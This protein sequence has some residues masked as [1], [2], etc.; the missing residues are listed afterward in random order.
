MFPPSNKP[1]FNVGANPADLDPRSFPNNPTSSVSSPSWEGA[2]TPS[3]KKV[4]SLIAAGGAFG[5]HKYL[6]AKNPNYAEGL[7]R[8]LKIAEERSPSHIGRTFALSQWMSSYLSHG[9]LSGTNDL[10]LFLEPKHLFTG[11][12]LTNTGEQV[13]RLLGL[14]PRADEF[15]GGMKF[16]RTSWSDPYLSLEGREGY[17][18]RFAERGRL[19]GSSF[20][21]GAEITKPVGSRSFKEDWWGSIKE[22]FS[23]AERKQYLKSPSGGVDVYRGGEKISFQPLFGEKPGIVGSS[24]LGKAERILFEAA[25]R[26]NRLLGQIGL[27]IESGTYNKLFHIPGIGEGGLLNKLFNRRIIPV[28]AGVTALRYL[29]YKLDNKPAEAI[30]GIPLKANVIRAEITDRF[31]GLRKLT[32]KYEDIVPGPQYGPLAL[33][34]AGAVVGGLLHYANVLKG[35]EFAGETARKLA[36]RGLAKKGAIIGAIAALPFV[37]GMIGSRK[38]AGELRSI[39]SGETE[40][41]IRSGR[42]WSLGSTALEGARIKYYRKHWY[43]L[44]KSKADIKSVYGSEEEYWDHNPLIHPFNYLKDPYWLEKKHFEDRPYPITSPAFTNVPLI[45]PLLAA[46]I[47]KLVKPVVRMHEKDWDTS[48]YTLYSPRLEPR[49]PI[50]ESKLEEM[51]LANLSKHGFQAKTQQVVGNFRLDMVVTGADGAKLAIEPEGYSYHHTPYQLKHD[52]ERGKILKSEGWQIVNVKSRPFFSNQEEAMKDVYDQLNK[53][54]IKPTFI[55]M[56]RDVNSGLYGLAPSIPREEYSLRDVI[57]GE[58]LSFAEYTGLPGFLATTIYGKVGPD[59]KQ[60]DVILQGSRQMTNYSRKYYERELGSGLGPGA[61][62]APFEYT[63]PFRRFIQPD[64]T[65]M[66]ANEIP[67]NMPDWLPGEDYMFSF[68]TGDPFSKIPEGTIRLPGRGYEALHSEVEGLDPGDYPDLTKY[69]IL[70]DV[71]PYSKEYMKYRSIIRSRAERDTNTSIEYE[72]TEEQ[73]RKMK[74]STVRFANRKFT[75]PVENISGTVKRVTPKGL[76]LSEYPERTFSFSSLG[77]SAADMSTLSLGAKNDATRSAV[78]VDVDNRMKNLYGYLE[79]TLSEGTAVNLVVPSGTEEHAKEARAVVFVGNTNINK[80][81]IEKGIALSRADLSGSESQAMH[82]TLGKLLGKYAETVS[83]QGDESYL[84]PLR[85]IPTPYHTKLW[86]NRTPLSQYQEQEVYGNRMRRWDRPIHDIVMPWV[87]GGIRRL[88]GNIIIPEMTQ[89]KRDMDSVT[90]ELSYLRGL[91]QAVAH[92]EMKGIHTSQAKRTNIGANQLGNPDFLST[93][94]P[95]R[96][97]LYFATFLA[98]NDPAKRQQILASVSPALT[99][100]LLAQWV[101]RDAE[102]ARANGRD[103]PDIGQDGVLY[104]KEGLS[105]YQ[106]AETDLS[107]ADYMRSR[108]IANTFSRTGFN[109]PDSDSE[110]W[111]ENLDYEDVKLKIIQ[112]EGYDLHDFNLY[113]DRSALLWRKPYIDGAVREL[114]S[115]GGQSAERIRQTVEKIILESHDRNPSIMTSTQMGRSDNSSVTVNVETDSSDEIDRDIRRNSEEYTEG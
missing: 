108:E 30:V 60:G 114:T 94:L 93:T 72:K 38:T 46:T 101:K 44:M 40:V 1:F 61:G 51:V 100:T 110:L 84:N 74:E 53:L 102:I 76:E 56:G 90:D 98:E 111:N 103:V 36:F 25:E 67:N 85:Y 78:A 68:K 91:Q 99:K 13:H 95:R 18:L 17:R 34:V 12:K 21:Y 39:Y 7:Y 81:M 59:G 97:K 88:T 48:N 32:D 96:D 26:P 92:P 109:I 64:K 63:E 16:V 37:P 80:E 70:A 86:Q 49:G 54:H 87:R 35:A 20:R 19:T 62:A 113:D 65:S 11:T 47:G 106:K 69:K 23:N 83:F 8:F 3:N 89:R 107:Y 112:N 28:L 57:K 33:P 75:E 10:G 45:G 9:K 29:N 104:T 105:E 71:A 6:L 77:M 31:P 73:V 5:L 41:P 43:S 79:N 2:D 82:G 50:V 52:R 115:G 22:K 14:D 4:I 55:G 42:W 24:V 15:A 58:A 66:Q 27:G